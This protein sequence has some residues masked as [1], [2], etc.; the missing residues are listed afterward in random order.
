MKRIITFLLLALYLNAALIPQL[1]EQDVYD[2]NGM[3]ADDINSVAEYV[4]VALGLD[5]TADDEDDDNGQATVFVKVI[6]YAREARD[7]Y[8]E[9]PKA[10]IENN[11]SFPEYR[12][13]FHSPP[14]V[15]I[16]TPPPDS[17]V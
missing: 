8:I 13:P 15:D 14:V 10:A 9:L 17:L 11:T 6:N 16:L 3:K 4:R 12:Q 1:P 7:C 2:V 5:K